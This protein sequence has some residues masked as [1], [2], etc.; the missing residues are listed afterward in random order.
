MAVV[1]RAVLALVLVASLSG[2][3]P[4]NVMPPRSTTPTPSPTQS[5]ATPTPSESVPATP[6]PD[7][8]RTQYP[9]KG[10]LQDESCV[11]VSRGLLEDLENL[12]EEPA[13]VLYTRGAMVK[14]DGPWW[15]IAVSTEVSPDHPEVNSNDVDLT[16]WFVTNTPDLAD[17]D[18]PSSWPLDPAANDDAADRAIHC[19]GLVPTPPPAPP[20]TDP[21]SYTGRLAPGATCIEVSPEMLKHLEGVG[22]VGG[23]ITYPRAQMVQANKKW[24]TIAVAT[25][26]HPNK[27]GHTRK[28]VPEV[29][30]FVTNA[31]SVEKGAVYFIPESVENDS[32]AAAA[33]RCLTG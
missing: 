7:P 26:V 23:A 5:A 10:R 13:I 22:R 30:Y 33:R 16:L 27:L 28:N 12:A 32:A 18:T 24:W 19:L 29:V 15:T 25:E 6:T 4:W 3:T 21:R 1:W 11:A 8:M 17:G 20:E 9:Y 2:C 14:A 31:P